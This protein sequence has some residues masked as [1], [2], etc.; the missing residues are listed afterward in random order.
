[1]Y[2]DLIQN[3]AKIVANIYI[4]QYSVNINFKITRT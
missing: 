2:L 3:K 1:M 4:Y